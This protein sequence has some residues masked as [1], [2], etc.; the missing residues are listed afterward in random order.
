MFKRMLSAALVCSLAIAA[1]P[2]AFAADNEVST[3]GGTG[4]SKVQLTADATTFDVTVPTSIA[5]KVNA[6]GSV[7]CPS[8]NAVKITNNSAGPIKVT[9]IEM[10]NGTWNLVSYNG[11]D[12]SAMAAAGV[13]SK[14]LG[15]QMT[16][17]TDVV[18]T[19]AEG[20]QTIAIGNQSQWIVEGADTAD[21]EL[22][23]ACAAIATAVSS[24]I[25]SG[26]TAATVVFT[27]AWN[28]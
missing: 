16:A 28:S 8:A 14:K 26:E 11:G 21:N 19:A 3:S 24:A 13:D 1:T 4:T 5:I 23:I 9:N 25:N 18:A 20:N 15:F 17:G 6:D 10:N 22:E 7:T 12:R 27:L 2:M